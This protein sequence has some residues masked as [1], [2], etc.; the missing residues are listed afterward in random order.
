MRV[1]EWNDESQIYWMK[2]EWEKTGGMHQWHIFH[3]IH[4]M[5]AFC[6]SSS[7]EY[8]QFGEHCSA[9]RRCRQ[10]ILHSH[11]SISAEKILSPKLLLCKKDIIGLH[12]V[13]FKPILLPT[14][15]SWNVSIEWWCM[16]FIIY[17]MNRDLTTKISN[18]TDL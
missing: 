17:H 3:V 16:D 9:L 1:T 4:K 12:S 14:E 7:G 10:K 18:D 6:H 15:D 13:D 8:W 11:F 2:D 5:T